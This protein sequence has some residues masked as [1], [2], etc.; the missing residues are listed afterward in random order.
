[1]VN[2]SCVMKPAKIKA[3][4]NVFQVKSTV[5]SNKVLTY[6]IAKRHS[7]KEGNIFYNNYRENLNR[8]KLNRLRKKQSKT[9]MTQVEWENNKDSY[10][11]NNI[12]DP[13]KVLNNKV[14]KSVQRDGKRTERC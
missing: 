12:D 8:D 13:N 10:L 6:F 11:I 5:R 2:K 3:N 9:L 1:M 14:Q 7:T 4:K